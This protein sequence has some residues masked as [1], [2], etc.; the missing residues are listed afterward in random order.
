[1][2]ELFANAAINFKLTVVDTEAVLIIELN[3]NLSTILNIGDSINAYFKR[4]HV[5]DFVPS[6]IVQMIPDG[7][8]L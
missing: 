6:E 2:Q 5:K 7:N 4:F 3:N 1:L 8:N